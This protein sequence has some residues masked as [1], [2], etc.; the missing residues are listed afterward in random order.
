MYARKAGRSSPV[1]YRL[2][3]LRDNLDVAAAAIISE[4]PFSK[5]VTPNQ[6]RE[7]WLADNGACHYASRVK[8]G[9]SASGKRNR[10]SVLWEFASL[11]ANC[12]DFLATGLPQLAGGCNLWIDDCQRCPGIDQSPD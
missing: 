2:T 11:S 6:A 10:G 3:P 12:V 1:A 9:E 7:E 5:Y 8:T 4:Q